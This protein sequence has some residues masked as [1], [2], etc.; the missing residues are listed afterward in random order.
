MNP[1][2][3]KTSTFLHNPPQRLIV[4]AETRSLAL[5]FL[6]TLCLMARKRPNPPRLAAL[7]IMA[8][9]ELTSLEEALEH[10]RPGE[11][12][13][14]ARR[15]IKALRSLLR[16]M[17]PALV[18]AAFENVNHA[19]RDAADALAGQRRAEALVVSAGKFLA[20]DGEANAYWRHLAETHHAAGLTA[21]SADAG[22]HAARAA[23]ARA[24]TALASA[25]LR[26]EGVDVLRR[27]LTRHYA[28]AR[29][30]LDHGLAS[31]NA[32]ELHEARKFVIHH[33]HHLSLLA[34][35][36]AAV[37]RRIA[38]LER[39]RGFLGDL[40]D[41]DEL[42]QVAEAQGK[43]A[44]PEATRRMEKVR[45]RLLNKTESAAKRLFQHRPRAMAD[46]LGVSGWTGN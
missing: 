32:E 21:M 13:H 24:S 26:D 10:A 19:L 40:N 18:E 23:L 3:K 36:L 30:L 38:D 35:H 5:R 17:K 11:S 33:L 28:R 45:A 20:G 12:V 7:K 34:P 31:G 41:L 44:S 22:L 37:R 2:G 15:R 6:G 39:L 42:T 16:L 27:S 43:T 29:R 14:G 4:T 8:E 1:L 9:A 25:E 46:R